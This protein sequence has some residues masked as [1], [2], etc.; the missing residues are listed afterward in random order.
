VRG[1]SWN[2]LNGVRPIINLSYSYDDN[3]ERK[4]CGSSTYCGCVC[5]LNAARG[6]LEECGV[7]IWNE[8]SRVAMATT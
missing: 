6:D 5:G 2:G 3:V 4:M 8:K 1:R 7:P